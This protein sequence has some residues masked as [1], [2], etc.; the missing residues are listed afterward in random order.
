MRKDLLFAGFIGIVIMAAGA[1]VSCATAPPAASG[2]SAGAGVQKSSFPGLPRPLWTKK[3]PAEAGYYVGIGSSNTG[4]EAED[5][6]TAEE[7]ARANIAA[8]ISTKIHEEVNVVTKDGSR[9]TSFTYAED[10]VSAEVEQSLTGVET[11]DTYSSPEAGAWVYMRLSKELWEKTQKREM[12]DLISRITNFLG[13]VLD[14]YD[15]PFIT[16]VQ[17]LIKARKLIMESPYP[18]MLTTVFYGEKG[19]LIDIIDTFL[20]EHMDSLSIQAAPVSVDLSVGKSMK[21]S[22]SFQSGVSSRVGSVPFEVINVSDGDRRIFAGITDPRGRYSGEIK[23][24]ALSM[25]KNHLRILPDRKKLGMDST[26]SSLILPEREM[27]VDLQGI[28]LGLE[29]VLP[30]GMKVPGIEGGVVSLFSRKELPFKVDS[31]N[32]G[33]HPSIRFEFVITDFPKV[34]KDAPQ[35]TQVYAVVSLVKGGKTMYSFESSPVKDGGITPEQAHKR[36]ADKLIKS[37]GS[38]DAYVKGILKA[39]SLN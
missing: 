8:E 35:M 3:F 26:V 11:V 14:D 1:F 30:K 29:V 34:L 37:L 10:R 13:P 25:G 31:R 23:Y 27:I 20:K 17:Q 7:R 33:T 36:A 19:A 2:S 24:T 21:F 6:K 16:R 32:G 5:M 12:A 4:N 39:L 15:R 38:D 9:G 28:T 18:G 22:V